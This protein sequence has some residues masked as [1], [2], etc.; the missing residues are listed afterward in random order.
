MAATESKVNTPGIT[1]PGQGGLRV[2]HVY[3]E[4]EN[5]KLHWLNEAARELHQE[6]VPVGIAD[7]ADH[8]MQTLE[9]NAATAADLPLV[10]AWREGQPQETTF[11][12]PRRGGKVDRV[13][14]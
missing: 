2:G 1:A 7:L 9:G 4:T 6:G 10:R 8:P 12:L 11:L 14:W 3:L 5:R 13:H